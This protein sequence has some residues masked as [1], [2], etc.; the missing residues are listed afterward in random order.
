M[1]DVTLDAALSLGFEVTGAAFFGDPASTTSMPVRERLDEIDSVG[2]NAEPNLEAIA[3]LEPDII[4]GWS[5]VIENSYDSLDEIASTVGLDFSPAPIDWKANLRKVAEILDRS[6]RVEELISDYDARVEE[7]RADLGGEPESV[8][9]SIIDPRGE[10]IAVYQPGSFSGSILTD[11]GLRLSPGEW[12]NEDEQFDEVSFELVPEY[13]GDMLVVLGAF[14]PEDEEQSGL[15]EDFLSDPLVQRL[16]AVREGNVH[17][18][19][20]IT[21]NNGSALTAGAVLDDI[22]RFLRED[23]FIEETE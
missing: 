21:W 18:I 8:T 23:G 22:E 16:E 20:G 1:D 14:D 11:V 4:F 7:L 19:T 13:D 2:L 6:E 17:T 15:A 3:A 5:L 9:V 10:T 12:E